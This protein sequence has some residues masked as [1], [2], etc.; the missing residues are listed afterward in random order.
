MLESAKYILH[1]M[2]KLIQLPIE[3][4]IALDRIFLSKNNNAHFIGFSLVTYYLAVVAFIRYRYLSSV[5][6]SMN[7]GASVPSVM[8]T[9]VMVR[10]NS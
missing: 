3:S 2:T 1:Q 8:L 4:L 10:E 5:N 7:V 9:P 6:F